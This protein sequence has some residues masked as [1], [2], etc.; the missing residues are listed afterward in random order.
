MWTCSLLSLQRSRTKSSPQEASS[1]SRH[2]QACHMNQTRALVT[3][4]TEIRFLIK[5]WSDE[6][7]KPT[8]ST[9]KP[10][11]ASLVCQVFRTHCV[12]RTNPHRHGPLI[13]FPT[14]KRPNFGIGR[15]PRCTR[16][17]RSI[18]RFVRWQCR[19]SLQWFFVFLISGHSFCCLLLLF[20][21][22]SRDQQFVRRKKKKT[23]PRAKASLPTWGG[24][25]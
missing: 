22:K 24:Y 9:H 18:Y 16:R 6:R 10:F 23:F 5:D 8:L 1:K 3:H 19:S 4:Q 11:P 21:Y 20:S 2:I 12:P 7:L 15:W 25:W 14:G 17:A 13:L